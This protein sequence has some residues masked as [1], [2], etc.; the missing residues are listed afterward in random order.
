MIHIFIQTFCQIIIAIASVKYLMPDIRKICRK[1]ADGGDAKK[2]AEKMQEKE[3]KT[4]NV[5]AKPA[6]TQQNIKKEEQ[7]TTSDIPVEPA[8]PIKNS[9]LEK[10]TQKTNNSKQDYDFPDWPGTV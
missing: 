10:D 2:K 3:Q 1:I 4:S 6:I 5:N 7:K 8:Q 9:N